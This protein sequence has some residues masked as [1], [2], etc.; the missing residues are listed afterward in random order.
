MQYVGSDMPVTHT[1]TTMTERVSHNYTANPKSLPAESEVMP[2]EKA[3]KTPT[4]VCTT[5]HITTTQNTVRSLQSMPQFVLVFTRLGRTKTRATFTLLDFIYF[6][7]GR[8]GGGGVFFF[9]SLIHSGSRLLKEYKNSLFDD[10]PSRMILSDKPRVPP[11][12]AD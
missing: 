9:H 8:G 10:R 6:G 11:E 12:V 3:T 5:A 1:F 7:G 2:T 4:R